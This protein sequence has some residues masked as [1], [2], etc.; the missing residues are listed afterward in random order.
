MW[1]EIDFSE[2]RDT[3]LK[4]FCVV[5][6]NKYMVYVLD[7]SILIQRAL[8]QPKTQ[9]SCI[10]MS[11]SE[12]TWRH[13]ITSYHSLQE[14]YTSSF[15]SFYIS[16]YNQQYF[17]FPKTYLTKIL[18]CEKSS[19]SFMLQKYTLYQAQP[20]SEPILEQED[21]SCQ[22]ALDRLLFNV[23][24]FRG[25]LTLHCTISQYQQYQHQK[26]DTQRH[27]FWLN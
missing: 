11:Y 2:C 18:K 7:Y 5:L 23:F 12:I 15:L 19:K 9:Y 6:I 17:L 22:K 21:T 16:L 25:E 13:S 1:E 3:L 14:K 24:E 8:L 26:L 4:Q 27:H 20:L 10:G